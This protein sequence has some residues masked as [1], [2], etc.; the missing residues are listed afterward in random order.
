M[1]V[2]TR[3]APIRKTNAPIVAIM[4]R[5]DSFQTVIFGLGWF[6]RQR[7]GVRVTEIVTLRPKGN[8]KGAKVELIPL[9][10]RAGLSGGVRRSP[11]E[12]LTKVVH[13]QVL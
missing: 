9:Y 5:L 10:F 3:M 12:N 11:D 6:N 7:N 2:P 4:R 8:R 1:G 13:N